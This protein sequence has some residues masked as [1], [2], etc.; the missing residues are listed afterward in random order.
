VELTVI[1]SVFNS[2]SFLEHFF[3]DI[4]RQSI[5][6]DCKF[7]MLDAN[8]TDNSRQIILEQCIKYDNIQYCPAGDRNI[9]ATWNLGIYLSD[10]E[11]LTNWN[12]DD[13]RGVNSL[14]RQLSFLKESDD[15]DLCYG[16]TLW[17]DTS[18]VNAEDCDPK[19]EAPCFPATIE[20]MLRFNSPH[21]LPVWRKSLHDRFGYF[22]DS[23]FSAGDYEMWMRALS[24][25][26]KFGMLD[27]VVGAYYRNPKGISSNPD[28]LD[29]AVA[30][31]MKIREIYA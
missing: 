30:E 14:E 28:N 21:C 9:Y 4:K 18:N 15:C 6:T 8:S 7:L 16:R 19:N 3:K 10:T 27:L 5:F 20:S 1:T 22:D 23:F 12:T 29:R 24:R 2:E 11:F 31:V 17:V 26:S 25:G 13:R